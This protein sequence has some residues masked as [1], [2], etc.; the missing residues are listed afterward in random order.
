MYQVNVS[1]VQ[2][3]CQCRFRWWC[4][5]IQ[6]R[7][8]RGGSPALDAGK[9]LHVMFEDHFQHGVPLYDAATKHFDA[10]TAQFPNLTGPDLKTAQDAAQIID[11]MIGAFPM[12]IDQYSFDEVL[13]VEQPFRLVIPSLAPDIEWLGRPDVM[14]TYKGR[15]WHRQNRGLAA[16]AN[17]G[18]Y[19][20]L[21]RRHYHEHLYAEYASRQYKKRKLKY[22]GTI[23]NLVR[24]LKY[25]TN[26]GKKNEKKKTYEE[27]FFTMPMSV[28]LKS[29]LHA[30]VMTSLVQHVREMQRVTHLW[31]S[32]R[33]IP[34][35]NPKMNGGF[36]GY[37]EDPYY[38]VLTGEAKLSDDTIFKD[39]EAT[40][41]VAE[42]E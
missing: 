9:L 25:H 8:P 38:K 1:S 40:Y 35:E 36:S 3:F 16:Q 2:D 14:G 27:M 22:G 19:M 39:R 12:W 11:D 20:R 18:V 24:K 33:V 21:A 34:A 31:E 41:A 6:N 32:E 15:I 4:K 5:W 42:S 10:F 30:S 28:D 17:F 29:G 23:F 13:E 7:V 26:V 37:V